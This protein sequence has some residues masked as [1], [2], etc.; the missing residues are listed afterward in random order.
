MQKVTSEFFVLQQY[1]I[2]NKEY[3]R[4]RSDYAVKII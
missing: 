2:E 3:T 1:N 4:F